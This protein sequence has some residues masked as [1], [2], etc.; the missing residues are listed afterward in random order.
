MIP[1]PSDRQLFW[2]LNEPF[3]GADEAGIV[4]HVDICQECQ[5]RLAELTRRGEPHPCWI[6]S[7]AARTLANGSAM[8][9]VSWFHECPGTGG[10]PVSTPWAEPDR[11]SDHARLAQPATANDPPSNDQDGIGTAREPT[12]FDFQEAADPRAAIAVLPATPAERG[13]ASPITPDRAQ[14]AGAGPAVD[15]DRTLDPCSPSAPAPCASWDRSRADRTEIPG[16]E[17]LEKLGEGGMGV[18]YKARQAGLNRLV[19]LKM[20]GCGSRAR[21][22]LVARFRTEAV[23]VARLRHPNILQVYDIGEVVGLPFLALELLEGGDLDDRLGG[24]PQ[25]C[26]QAAEL[27]ATLARAVHAAHRARIVHRDLKPRNVLFTA[28]G[29]PKITDFGLAKQLESDSTQ[30]ETGAIM[31]SPSYMAPEQARGYSKDVG[32]AADVYALGTILYEMLTGR[33]PFKGATP[34]ETLRQVINDDPVP[35][36]R[37][38]PRLARDLET[39]CLKCLHKEPRKRYDSAQDLADDL[40]RYRHSDT[41]KARR[42]PVWERGVKWS[43]R[44]PVAAMF[45]ASGLL[46]FLGLT[47]GGALFE[48]R[49]RLRLVQRD[50]RFLRDQNRGMVLSDQ[51]DTA[52]TRDELEHALNVLGTFHPDVEIEPRLK[53]ISEHVAAK[54]RSVADR[55]RIINTREAAR[56]GDRRDRDRFQEFLALHEEAQLYASGLGVLDS[57]DRVQKLRSSA[58]DALRAYARDPRAPSTAWTLAEPLPAALSEAEKTRVRDGCYDVLLILSQAMDPAEGLRILERADRVRPAKTAAYHLRRA[59][60]LE[61]AGDRAGR[62]RERRAA[63]QHEPATA[64]DYFLSGRELAACGR[65]A[66]AIGLLETAVQRDLDQTSAHLLLAVCY[67]NQRPKQLSA[68]RA[69]LN[70]CIRSHPDLVGLYLMRASIFGEEG[71][72]AQGKAAADAFAAAEADYRRALERQPTDDLRYGLLANRGL[73]RLRSGRLAESVADLDAAIRLKPNQYQAHTTLG[74][75]LRRQGRLDAAAAAFGRA[76]ACHPE[77]N[78]LAGLYRTRA[79]IFAPRRD[80]TPTQQD[81]ALRDLEEAIRRESDAALRASDH[82]WRARIFL[83][84]GQPEA[85]LAASDAALQLVAEDPQ[86]H[87]VRVAALMELKRYHAVLASADAYLARG[88]PVAP[89]LEIRGLARIQQRDYAGAIADYSRALELQQKSEPARRSRLLNLRGWAYHFAD[90]PKLALSDFEESLG[91]EPNRSDALG[92]RGLARIRLGQWRPAVA[93]AE[94]ALRHARGP[95]AGST[96]ADARVNEVQALANAARIYA[97]AVECAAQDVSRHGERA[98][99]LYRQYR[100]RAA[101]LLDEVLRRVP[102]RRRREEILADP[103]FRPLHLPPVRGSEPGPRSRQAGLAMGRRDDR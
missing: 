96:P 21:T 37:L 90:A 3:D 97:L 48:R 95:G 23:A 88:Q 47:L 1:C 92:G 19:A 68:A 27:V 8:P 102:D 4:A 66:D 54:R 83:G 6:E 16:Y 82:V 35:P 85:A 7:H 2:L 63:Q 60:C 64:L 53:P 77:P 61:R 101:E 9:A 73:L 38:V 100:A 89:I 99:A 24:T 33:P 5:D 45:V 58:H 31:G 94:A 34:M 76:I 29:V 11:I 57:A 79:L 93:D 103:S 28:D 69:S 56:E 10:P 22:D 70:A 12:E 98:V 42:T 15:E 55:L 65:F 17:I 86:A 78:I 52:S 87:R 67:L 43:R 71:S 44:R 50:E 18:V 80:L 59:D 40:D 13:L 75:V 49:E 25:P 74:Q 39:I 32:P 62:D 36:S 51:A 72:Q 91:L 84:G 14:G 26:R 81:A 30:T 41:I 20:I 46:T